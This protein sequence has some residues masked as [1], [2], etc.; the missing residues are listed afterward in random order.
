[1]NPTTFIIWLEGYLDGVS[2]DEWC[3]NLDFIRE[4][5]RKIEVPAAPTAE[6]ENTNWSLYKCQCKPKDILHD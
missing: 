1:M 6:E 5:L 4:K 2:D 3:D